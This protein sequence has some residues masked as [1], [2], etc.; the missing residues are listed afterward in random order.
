LD[1]LPEDES[2]KQDNDGDHRRGGK[3]DYTPREVNPLDQPWSG[4]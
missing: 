2:Q 3:K 4:P 1:S